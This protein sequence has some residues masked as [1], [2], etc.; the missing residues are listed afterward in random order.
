MIE[1]APLILLDEPEVFLRFRGEGAQSKAVIEKND[2][3]PNARHE[4]LQIVVEFGELRV[5]VLE[6]LIYRR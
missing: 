2:A 6:L 1:G 4:I 3:D 5:L